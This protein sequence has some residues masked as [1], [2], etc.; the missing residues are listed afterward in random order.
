MLLKKIQAQNRNDIRTKNYENVVKIWL[1]LSDEK[2]VF[3]KYLLAVN[4]ENETG[5]KHRKTSKRRKQ[6]QETS[7]KIR[8]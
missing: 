5:Y 4:E 1:A 2:E 8:M 3:K 7:L 6:K